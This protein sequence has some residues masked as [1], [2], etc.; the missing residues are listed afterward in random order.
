MSIAG[1]GLLYVEFRVLKWLFSVEENKKYKIM[2]I[3]GGGIKIKR[4]KFSALI[5][6]EVWS[7]VY[8]SWRYSGASDELM[9]YLRFQDSAPYS[10]RANDGR[11]WLVYVCCLLERGDKA[12]AVRVLRKYI[13][14]FGFA[15]IEN[16][17]PA[18]HLARENGFI[19]PLIEKAA[20]IFEKFEEN[21]QKRLFENMVKNGTVAI[22]GNGPSEAGK[23]RGAE[24]D[25]HDTVIRFNGFSI[26]DYKDDYGTK[27]D[28]WVKNIEVL[29]NGNA[30]AKGVKL[31]LY[32]QDYW[33]CLFQTEAFD[34]AQ[35]NLED[36]CDYWAFDGFEAFKEKAD[37][38]MFDPTA[39][40]FVAMWILKI[41]GSFEGV[42]FYGFSFL[43]P[44]YRGLF[45][46]YGEKVSQNG[47]QELHHHQQESEI[48][49]KMV[50]G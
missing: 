29:S 46:Y 3:L 37:A 24:I 10:W 27:T 40:F 8:S 42:D 25:A 22:V 32:K 12:E 4:K 5:E 21:R 2:N 33:H 43:E 26:F 1:N 34:L 39:G 16:F 9:S 31:S 48:L 28:I 35:N 14:F 23:K 15:G 13:L 7:M 41:R 47:I 19:N 49:R 50:L 44:E 20:Y 30:E 18:A 45:H 6:K 36:A 38:N 17:L 11:I